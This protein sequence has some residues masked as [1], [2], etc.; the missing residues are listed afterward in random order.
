MPHLRTPSGIEWYYELE[1]QGPVILF[2][3]GWGCNAQVWAQQV[4][5]FA[6]T[7]RMLTLDLPGHGRSCWEK[8]GVAQMARDV[9][10]IIE[11]LG[12]DNAHGVASSLGALLA[13]SLSA[14]RPEF[15]LSLTTVGSLPKFAQDAG[16]PYGL[17]PHRIR[18]LR[19]QLATDYPAIVQIFF[20]SLFTKEERESERFKW[21]DSFRAPEM[22]PH[23]EAL[24]TFLDFVE[25][26]DWRND[27]ARLRSPLFFISGTE[28]YICPLGSVEYLKSVHSKARVELFEGCGHFPFLSRPGKFNDLLAKF[29]ADSEQR[30]AD[31]SNQ[32][33][34]DR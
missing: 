31:S 22:V 34:R 9:V 18:K 25:F 12:I 6:S 16:Y 19:Q 28:D 4:K 33:K 14:N 32:F 21:L 13:F 27:F 8:T 24:E 3:H 20:R 10:H 29:L 15:F 5:H 26:E 30:I 7:H 2:L 1:G 23:K 11:T 17:A